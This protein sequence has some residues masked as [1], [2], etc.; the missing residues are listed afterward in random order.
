MELL[1]GSHNL[2]EPFGEC[3]D[4]PT[5]Q[6]S[7]CITQI[8]RRAVCYAENPESVFITETSKGVGLGLVEGFLELP[9]PPKNVFASCIDPDNNEAIE[10]RDIASHNPTVTLVKLD[11]RSDAD[12]ANAVTTVQRVLGQRGLN[13][14]INNAAI[15]SQVYGLES[16]TRDDIMS[17]CD[18][19]VAAP[20]AV[21]ATMLY[22]E[23]AA[24][25]ILVAGISPGW[26]KTEMGGPGALITLEESAVKCLEQLEILGL[27]HC[28]KELARITNV[29]PHSLT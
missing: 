17:H 6:P 3:E 11:V 26:V 28:G 10:L 16:L 9:N 7:F 14:L 24:D 27:E 1:T 20:S 19:S 15:N 21:A 13:L 12:I 25:E 23:L 2:R 5:L 18:C 29:G 4:S 22:R 8:V